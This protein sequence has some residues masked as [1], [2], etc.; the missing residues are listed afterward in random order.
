MMATRQAGMGTGGQAAAAKAGRAET[1]KASYKAWE[2][3][4][5][6]H[7]RRQQSA[8]WPTTMGGERTRPGGAADGTG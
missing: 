1:K 7:G 3:R 6:F 5:A 8:R 2:R 4:V